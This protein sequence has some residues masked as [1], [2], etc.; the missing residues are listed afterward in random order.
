MLAWQLL[1]LCS[2]IFVP[3]RNVLGYLKMHVDRH[4]NADM[5]SGQYA[6]HAQTMLKR[7]LAMGVRKVPPSTLEVLSVLQGSP[8]TRLWPMTCTVKLPN[9]AVQVVG[10]DAQ[11]TA[12]EAAQLVSQ[13]LGLRG[14]ETT[15]FALSATAQPAHGRQDAT[16][17]SG[18]GR[19]RRPSTS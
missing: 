9:G 13:N 7:T 1:C 11:S 4:A 14:V 18:R 16:W 15:G 6:M 5:A 8:L 19:S 17:A 2:G 3:T 10:F 12:G